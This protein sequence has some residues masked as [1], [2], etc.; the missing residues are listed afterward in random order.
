[1]DTVPKLNGIP[2][3]EIEEKLQSEPISEAV[4]EFNIPERVLRQYAINNDIPFFRN[5]LTVSI[6][7]FDEI[8]NGALRSDIKKYDVAKVAELWQLPINKLEKYKQQIR[9]K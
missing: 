6:K 4:K 8:N 5:P 2:Y 3:I 7:K 9:E 1:M